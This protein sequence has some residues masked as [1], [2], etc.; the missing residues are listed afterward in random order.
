MCATLNIPISEGGKLVKVILRVGSHK[1]P[2][3]THVSKSQH[4]AKV[5]TCE[6]QVITKIWFIVIEVEP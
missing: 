5:P 6:I 3:L 1:V 4:G 2:S